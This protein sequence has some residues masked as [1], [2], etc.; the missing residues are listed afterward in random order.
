VQVHGARPEAD[1][2]RPGA[3]GA[4]GVPLRS[5]TE[6]LIDTTTPSGKLVFGIFGPMAEFERDMLRQRATVGLAAAR[7]RGR[8]GGRPKLMSVDD[9]KKA[10]ALLASGDYTRRQVADELGVS[11]HTL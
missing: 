4:C 3:V 1:K 5:L 2:S 7:K 11:R 9:L 6:N 8:V 10:Q